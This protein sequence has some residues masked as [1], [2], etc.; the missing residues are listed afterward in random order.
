MNHK[1][2]EGFFYDKKN[3]SAISGHYGIQVP[4]QTDE[5]F[6]G[7]RNVEGGILIWRAFLLS[8]WEPVRQRKNPAVEAGLFC[9]P[10]Y[11]K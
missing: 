9:V 6:I 8:K 2:Q 4:L 5:Y 1:A 3:G 10:G 11:G 7:D